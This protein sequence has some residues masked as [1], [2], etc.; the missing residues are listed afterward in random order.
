MGSPSQL[1][2]VLTNA[3]ARINAAENMHSYVMTI[4]FLVWLHH[5]VKRKAAASLQLKPITTAK[6]NAVQRRSLANN[7]AKKSAMDKTS[8]CGSFL[9]RLVVSG[10]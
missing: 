9:S 1:V 4:T 7:G 10:T 8:T 6:A 5:M 3:R 2:E